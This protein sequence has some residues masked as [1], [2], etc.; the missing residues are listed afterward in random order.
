MAYRGPKYSRDYQ[1]PQETLVDL[2]RLERNRIRNE[3]LTIQNQ[4]TM[5]GEYAYQGEIYD[6]TPEPWHPH[7]ETLLPIGA[8]GSDPKKNVDAHGSWLAQEQSSWLPEGHRRAGDPR[9]RVQAIENKRPYLQGEPTPMVTSSH[10]EKSTD[11]SV[12][13]PSPSYGQSGLSSY[14]ECN[15]GEE[16]R[17]AGGN[18]ESLH[19]SD[20]LPHTE[21]LE[22][23]EHQERE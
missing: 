4:R 14:H 19:C 20:A 8:M 11:G 1:Q 18:I 6:R 5:S 16:Q 23:K 12:R 9:Y 10:G 3:R 15:Q 22:R 7:R 2:I 17:H 13:T 21:R